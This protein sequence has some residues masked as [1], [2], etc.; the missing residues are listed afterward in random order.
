MNE[1]TQWDALHLISRYTGRDEI[2]EEMRFPATMDELLSALEVLKKDPAV[3]AAAT[4]IL[5]IADDVRNG[6]IPE[7]DGVRLAVKMCQDMLIGQRTDPV[8]R[9]RLD[10]MESV[11]DV[12]SY[13]SAIKLMDT[14]RERRVADE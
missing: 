2:R 5:N 3:V 6:L 14:V 7:R 10:N 4:V 12:I 11:A 8:E 9:I 1:R 13:V